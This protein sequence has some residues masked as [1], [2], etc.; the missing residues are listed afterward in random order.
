MNSARAILLALVLAAACAGRAGAQAFE[1]DAAGRL[2]AAVYGGGARID[3][4]YQLDD[5]LTNV[6]IAGTQAATDADADGL[7]DAWEWVY[8]NDLTHGPAADP[9]LNGKDNLWEFQ[10]G[11]DPLDP[12]SDGDGALNADETA[13]GTDP[14]DADSVFKVAGLAL[15]PAGPVVAWFG[16]SSRFYRV[17]RATNLVTGFESLQSNVPAVWPQNVITD[18]TVG[19]VTA[20]FYRI[21]L[22]DP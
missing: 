17:Q 3:Y 11:Y 2:G 16:V 14:L 1:Y 19:S 5:S 20:R 10:N 4:R 13:A 22:E 18:R 21:Q 12:D 9:N 8:F 15:Q 7:P 6:V